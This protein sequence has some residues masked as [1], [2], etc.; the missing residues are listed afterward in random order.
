VT[1]VRVCMCPY[2]ADA[3]LLHWIKEGEADFIMSNDSDVIGALLWFMPTVKKPLKVPYVVTRVFPL[4][5]PNAGKVEIF[6]LS[7]LQVRYIL[8]VCDRLIYVYQ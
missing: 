6:D 2:E 7:M 1:V 3:Q 5:S 8:R 4:E